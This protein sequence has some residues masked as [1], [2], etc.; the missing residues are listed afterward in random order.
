MFRTKELR[1]RVQELELRNRELNQRYWEAKFRSKSDFTENGVKGLILINGGS[2]IALGA[3]LQ[4]IIQKPEA[5]L[6]IRFVLA[7]LALNALGVAIAAAIFWLRYMQSLY[8]DRKH[9]LTRDNPWWWAA[10]GTSL[11]SVVLFVCAIGTV[12]VGGF[13]H[14]G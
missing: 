12:V 8:E 13:I 10:W 6:L 3:F 11:L 5:A 14:L 9:G 1:L 7:G 2:A 4:A